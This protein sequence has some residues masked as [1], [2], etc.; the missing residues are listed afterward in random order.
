MKFYLCPRCGY[1]TKIKTHM[2]NHLNRTHVCKPVL[3]NIVVN[4][5][6][7]NILTNNYYDE[8][9]EDNIFTNASK[10]PQNASKNPQ[11]ASKNPQN[12]SKCLK[13]TQ[14]TSKSIKNNQ[15]IIKSNNCYNFVCENCNKR[16]SRRDNL[17]RHR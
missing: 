17:N 9:E 6:I 14:N 7:E 11:N 3:S 8:Y 2:R 16:Y 5:D 10:N 15:N 1:K 4:M 13:I 12:H